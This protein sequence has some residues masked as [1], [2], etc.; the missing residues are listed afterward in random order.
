MD[1]DA[2]LSASLVVGKSV[3]RGIVG[4]DVFAELEKNRESFKEKKIKQKKEILNQR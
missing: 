3:A 1:T 2:L 4:L